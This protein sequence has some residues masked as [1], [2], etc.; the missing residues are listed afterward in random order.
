[1]P[2]HSFKHSGTLGDII[3]GLPIMRHFGG[4]KFY[5]HLDQINYLSRHYY[6][7]EPPAFQRDRMRQ[8]DFDFLRSFFESQDYITSCEVLDPKTHEITHNLDR[9]RETFIRHPGNY[10]DCYAD[11]FNITDA[12]LKECLRQTPWLT[13]PETKVIP[14]KVAVVNRTLRWTSPTLSSLWTDWKD[15]GLDREAVFVG[16]P[17]EYQAFKA[18]TGWDIDY[19]PCRDLLE[20]ASV[21][22][23]AE[24][25]IGNQSAALSIAIGLGVQFW[26]EGRKD[27]PIERNECYFPEQPNGFYF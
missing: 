1:M 2:Q 7:V 23:G 14:G 25:F 4:G 15:N 16:L 8:S 19:Y 6:G 18:A 3:Y 10:V 20:M 9:F 17:D 5:L 21:I 24:S 27:L 11:T 12:T 13:V 26:C 22:A